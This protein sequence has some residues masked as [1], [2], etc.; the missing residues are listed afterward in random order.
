MI[1]AGAD[2]FAGEPLD[3]RAGVDTLLA[4]VVSAFEATPIDSRSDG[5]K[6]AA[7]GHAGELGHTAAARE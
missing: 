3:M 1:R 4:R 6:L 7:A 5:R 2:L